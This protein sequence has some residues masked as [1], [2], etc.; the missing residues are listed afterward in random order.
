MTAGGAGYTSAPTVVVSGTGS[1][2][3]K[4]IAVLVKTGN[5]CT[6]CT[7]S[8]SG[9]GPTTCR[10]QCAA[11]YSK[12]ASGGACTVMSHTHERMTFCFMLADGVCCLRAL[13]LRCAHS[14]GKK[15]D[16][17]SAACTA[18]ETGKYLA[19]NSDSS[20]TGATCADCEA[21]KYLNQVADGTATAA[22]CTACD[23][24]QKSFTG[25]SACISCEPGK[26]LPQTALKTDNACLDCSDGK[27]L[28]KNTA[29][30]A[31]AASCTTCQAGSFAT[32]G[33]SVCT[34]CNPGQ[35][36]P[37]TGPAG[38]LVTGNS[39]SNCVSGKFLALNAA[40]TA[41]GAV[42]APCLAGQW[43]AS[44]SAACSA[45]DPGKYLAQTGGLTGN[46]AACTNCAAGKYILQT[47]TGAAVVTGDT[48]NICAAGYYGAGATC[49][50]RNHA[51]DRLTTC[52]V[53]SLVWQCLL[54]PATSVL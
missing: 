43:S 8:I 22:A 23:A 18:C 12:G 21:G 19:Q 33:K 45:C 17:G 26:Y 20:A 11:G 52:C 6:P 39:C 3:A 28:D 15:S 34:A 46:Q 2:N 35:Y 24:G 16:P 44:T 13:L 9:S 10:S 40:G 37:Q 54:C 7:A 51:P 38:S 36:L 4:A 32:T 41:T 29:R 48:C 50:V 47:G 1:S 14:V 5:S 53:L 42:C 27:Y 30:T 49:T 25:S 31:T